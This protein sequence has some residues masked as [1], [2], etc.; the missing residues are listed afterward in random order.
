MASWKFTLGP[1][2]IVTDVT[3]NTTESTLTFLTDQDIGVSRGVAGLDENAQLPA[4]IIDDVSKATYIEGDTKYT[5]EQVLNDLKKT[6]ASNGTSLIVVKNPGPNYELVFDD[7]GTVDKAYIITPNVNLTLSVS[8]GVSNMIQ[9]MTF[10][11]LQPQAM[12][13]DVTLPDQSVVSWPGDIP[14]YINTNPRGLTPLMITSYGGTYIGGG[15]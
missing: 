3:G 9:R 6:T 14:P 13:F 2:A 15:S 11:I 7:T 4:D 5:L 10:L 1:H 8:G 12:G